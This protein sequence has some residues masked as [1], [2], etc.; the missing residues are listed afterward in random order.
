VNE[1]VNV[2]KKSAFFKFYP[3][4]GKATEKIYNLKKNPLEDKTSNV[5]VVLSFLGITQFCE[6]ADSPYIHHK[7]RLR[8]QPF[9][10]KD[11]LSFRWNSAIRV[12]CAN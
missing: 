4:C 10:Q 1:A 3:S 11:N 9:S 6:G 7:F 5:A 8:K 2:N 12:A